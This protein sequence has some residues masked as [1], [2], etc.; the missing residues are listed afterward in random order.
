[1]HLAVCV[2]AVWC[3]WTAHDYL[4]ERVFLTPGFHF[5]YAMAFVLQAT[6]FLLSLSYRAGDWLLEWGIERSRRRQEE[7]D[8]DEARRRAVALDEEQERGLLKE[9]PVPDDAVLSAQRLGWVQT[10]A[11]YVL[12]SLIHI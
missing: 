6:S 2:A 11:L 3:T 8:E 12:L 10:L 9:A 7:E 1:M 4:Q 5:G